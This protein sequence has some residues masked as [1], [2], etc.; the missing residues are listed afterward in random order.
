MANALGTFECSK[1]AVDLT[2]EDNRLGTRPPPDG[3]VRAITQKL[4]TARR[5]ARCEG[6]QL[7]SRVA[8]VLAP[9]GLPRALGVHQRLN[10]ARG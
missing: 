8:V 5:G 7:V 2:A 3:G 4:L 6:A 10:L 9:S 1:F